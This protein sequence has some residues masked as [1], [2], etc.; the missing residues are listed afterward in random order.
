MCVQSIFLL[1]F[2]W[3]L[4]LSFFGE[5]FD[6]FR[7]WDKKRVLKKSGGFRDER[8]KKFQK[9]FFARFIKP[10][11]KALPSLVF[12]N[13]DDDDFDDNNSLSCNARAASSALA[14]S[15]S[16]SSTAAARFFRRS[17]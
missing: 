14:S 7:V 16:S 1:S 17:R 2:L 5:R 10:P 8:K 6:G 11:T 12:K 4:F 15:S 9:L 13:D 3:S